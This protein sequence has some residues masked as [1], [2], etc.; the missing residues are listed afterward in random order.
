MGRTALLIA[1]SQLI[2]PFS[3][4]SRSLAFRA[5]L[6]SVFWRSARVKPLLSDFALP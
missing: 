2:V 1:A 3:L 5:V 6:P 4:L